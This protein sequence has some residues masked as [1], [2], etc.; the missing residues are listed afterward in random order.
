M[1]SPL[2]FSGLNFSF[3]NE[4]T[5]NNICNNFFILVTTTLLSYQNFPIGRGDRKNYQNLKRYTKIVERKVSVQKET[6]DK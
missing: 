5:L 6:S 1:K 4:T 2:P 3:H